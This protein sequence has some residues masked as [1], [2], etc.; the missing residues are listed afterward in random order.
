MR[1]Q[2]SAAPTAETFV[3]HAR[4]HEELSTP[5]SSWMRWLS[6]T[7]ANTP[8]ASAT[9]GMPDRL[10]P[11]IAVG[12]H[13]A[14]E[15]HLDARA[16]VGMREI[17]RQDAPQLVDRRLIEAAPGVADGRPVEGNEALEDLQILGLTERG[18]SGDL[19]LVLVRLEA[20]QV[21]DVG[22]VVADRI[23]AVERRQRL[24]PAVADR[25]Y[26]RA[27]PVAGSVMRDD[28]RLVES[29]T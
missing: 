10:Y 28:R 23:V 17:G 19:A 25:I 4:M 11:V 7:L 1:P 26:A 5:G 9:C 24:E 13:R 3:A 18:E 8:P 16:Q 29:R 15:Q 22:V 12:G 6:L 27:F 2:S 20:A 14:L 21:R